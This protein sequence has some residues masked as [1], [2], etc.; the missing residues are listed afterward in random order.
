MAVRRRVSLHTARYR[1]HQEPKPPAVKPLALRF[2]SLMLTDISGSAPPKR[3]HPAAIQSAM[4]WSE[5]IRVP[6]RFSPY[7]LQAG[8]STMSQHRPPAALRRRLHADYCD[9]RRYRPV[10]LAGAGVAGSAEEC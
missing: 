10:R 8:E 9:R 6:R 1:P 5:P 2:S 3:K 7:W 4:R